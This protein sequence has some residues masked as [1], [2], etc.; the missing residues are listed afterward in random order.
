MLSAF[1]IALREGVEAALV[2]GIVLVYLRK[3]ARPDLERPVWFGVAAALLASGVLAVA[4]VRF[5]WNQETLEGFLL[6]V[7]ALLLVTMIVWMQRV[8]RH[9]RRNIEHRVEHLTGTSRFAALGLFLF[10][11]AM[12]LREGVET[13]LMLG[14]V[15]VSSEGLLLLMGLV[16]GLA[17]A[18]GLGVFFFKGVLPVRL[19]RFFH[20]TSVILIIIAIQLTLTGVHELSEAMIIPSGPRL[21]SLLG[22][23]VR[24]DVFFLVAILGAAGWLVARELLARRQA[25]LAL[26]GLKEAEQRRQRWRQRQQRRW[27]TAA[28]VTSLSVVLILTAE[29][30]YART[31]QALSP[32]RAVGPVGE[33]IRIPVSEVADGNLHRYSWTTNG[34]TIR[35]IVIR[36]PD[37]SLATALDACQICGIAGYYQRGGNVICKNCA[38]VIY[39]PSIGQPGGCNPIPLDSRI[40][41]DTLLIR[42][43]DL[44]AMSS[45]FRH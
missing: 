18:V 37:G 22:P 35:F 26:R 11:F 38:A 43:H 39:I 32:A 30:V 15:S 42:A 13:V 8:A 16:L 1:I 6:L 27:M 29:Y 23:I 31:E 10:V 34:V 9:L 2:V 40:E 19:D 36:Q 33:F 25:A 45:P 14:A 7:A 21:M 44:S 28:A 41:G 17:I 4:L 20:V 3:I 12:V 5:A 24:N